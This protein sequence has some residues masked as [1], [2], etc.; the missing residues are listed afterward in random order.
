MLTIDLEEYHPDAVQALIEYMYLR[1]WAV[2][3]SLANERSAS[4]LY[5]TDVKDLSKKYILLGQMGEAADQ[6]L[7]Y[8]GVLW[9]R[10]V[11]AQCITDVFD[12]GAEKLKLEN[13][14]NVVASERMRGLYRENEQYAQCY[15]VAKQLLEFVEHLCSSLAL[16]GRPFSRLVWRKMAK[17][18]SNKQSH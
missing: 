9:F 7:I 2:L 17:V 4:V 6:T 3:R 1:T 15:Q 10:P 12:N 16:G 18:R 11:L 14:L 5:T 8:M 13:I